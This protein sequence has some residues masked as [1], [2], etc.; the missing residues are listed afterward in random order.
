MQAE[1]NKEKTGKD[2]VAPATAYDG[3]GGDNG[4]VGAGGMSSNE[5]T[6]IQGG[7]HQVFKLSLWISFYAIFSI[8]KS[9]I[10]FFFCVWRAWKYW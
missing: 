2:D 4:V 8:K 6:N 7:F 5:Q 10:N 1:K 3:G 9:I